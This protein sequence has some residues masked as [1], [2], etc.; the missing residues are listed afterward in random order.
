MLEFA[1][2]T[3]DLFRQAVW[4]NPQHMDLI[5]ADSFRLAVHD[6]GLVDAN[7][8]VNFYEGKVRVR[9]PEGVVLEEYD[10][11]RYLDHLA[12]R[13]ETFSYLKFPYLR[14]KGWKGF[15]E[16]EDSGVYRCGPLGR[17]NAADGMATPL[18]QAA[19]EE[20][21]AALG[22]RPVHA[23]LA[24]HWARLVELLYAAER[25][26]ELAQEDGLTDPDVRLVPTATP[27][28]GVGC[29]EA[30]R[31]TLTHHYQSDAKGLLTR[32]NML[33]G[34]TNNNAAM[35][36]SVLKAAR[37]VLGK[38]RKVTEGLLNRIEMSFR[39]YDPCMSCATHGL[40]GRSPLTVSLWDSEGRLLDRVTR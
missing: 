16:G 40:P 20:M 37:G 14:T 36:L 23:T 25:W 22:G 9:G 34:T 13:V 6:M 32:V 3:L 26:C 4:A 8:K 15:T 10:P 1:K 19:Y 38:G 35:S 28:E 12:E 11:S 7:G 30:P 2:W 5:T 39:A 29:V 27:T 21:Y 24:F 17:L 31:G 33:V 18:A